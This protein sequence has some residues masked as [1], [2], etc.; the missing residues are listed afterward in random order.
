MHPSTHL[1][2]IRLD[3]IGLDWIRFESIRLD[4]TNGLLWST[5]SG[6]D[7]ALAGILMA[8]LKHEQR[9][10]PPERTRR[11]KLEVKTGQT[12]EAQIHG[13]TRLTK[14]GSDGV[15]RAEGVRGSS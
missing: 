9:T 14:Q 1:R 3:W 10:G 6:A 12:D 4:H 11:S 15:R 7:C 5:K 8:G 2:Q 13:S